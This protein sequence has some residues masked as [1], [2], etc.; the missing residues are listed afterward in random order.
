MNGILSFFKTKPLQTYEFDKTFGSIPD[1]VIIEILRNLPEKN[2]IGVERVCLKWNGLIKVDIFKNNHPISPIAFKKM[3]IEIIKQSKN[4]DKNV[5]RGH[6]VLDQET[7]IYNIFRNMITGEFITGELI[8]DP[9]EEKKKPS[10]IPANCRYL[11]KII[12]NRDTKKS[13]LG[14]DYKNIIKSFDLKDIQKNEMTNNEYD[15]LIDNLNYLNTKIQK[16]N[17]K[18]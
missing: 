13:M 5:M 6:S 4:F 8:L 7:C 17:K 12:G 14:L 10:Q 18:I 9:D 16:I 2:K 15:A 11:A 3:N 1:E